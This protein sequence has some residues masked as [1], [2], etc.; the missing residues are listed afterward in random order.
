MIP[1]PSPPGA[2]NFPFPRGYAKIDFDH[3]TKKQAQNMS[4]KWVKLRRALEEPYLA[5]SRKMKEMEDS[6]D[7]KDEKLRLMIEPRKEPLVVVKQEAE[8]RKA[9]CY[10]Q[11]SFDVPKAISLQ[12]K[13]DTEDEAIMRR[14]WKI[15][16][17]I[18]HEKEIRE[19]RRLAMLESRKP[20]NAWLKGA[21]KTRFKVQEEVAEEEPEYTPDPVTVQLV[22]DWLSR[23]FV[24]KP[25]PLLLHAPLQIPEIVEVPIK[26]QKSAPKPVRMIISKARW[27]SAVSFMEPEKR[28]S[29]SVSRKS[30]PPQRKEL[31]IVR[32]I[33]KSPKIIRGDVDNS[34]IQ[35]YDIS[36]AK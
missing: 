8:S 22:N 11:P 35:G 20:G 31:I 9:A 12:A 33:V 3:F 23:Y 27:S 1:Q 5:H 16:H 30:K 6:Y 15:R 17:L 24:V 28:V 2:R 34:F 10:H 32:G 13:R 4:E 14:Q 36:P 26:R 7:K 25:V 19:A 29:K 21:S 18:E